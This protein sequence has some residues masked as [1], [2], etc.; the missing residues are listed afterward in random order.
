MVTPLQKTFSILL[1]S[2]LVFAILIT[3]GAAAKPTDASQAQTSQ[4]MTGGLMGAF[5]ATI[6]S[7]I[8]LE[9]KVIASGAAN[10]NFGWSVAVSGDTA[11]VGAY[12]EDV[13]VYSNQGSA[14]V[15]TRSAGTWS[16]QQ[17]LTASDGGDTDQ[18]GCSVALSGDGNTALIGAY[19]H[20]VDLNLDQGSAYVFVRSGETWTQQGGPLTASD[21]AAGDQ[22]GS[23]VALSGHTALV[24]SWYDDVAANSDQGTVYVF[25]RSGTTWTQ[26][27][28]PL[29]ASD[30]AAGDHFGNSVAL[31][32]DTA[33][34][35]AHGHDVDLNNNQGSAYIFTRSG[36]IWTQQ[37]DPLTGSDSTAGDEF[38]SSVALSGDTA[39]VGV[40]YD[41][42]GG[43][44][45]QGSAY[46]FT[47]SGTTWTQQAQLIAADGELGD[48]FGLSVALDGDTALVGAI[49]DDVGANSNQ[50]SVYIFARSGT[51]WTQ[52]AQLIAADGEAQ[53]WFGR[54]VALDGDTALAGT[55][56]NDAGANH[57][58]GAAYVFTGSGTSWS[59]QQKITATDG[60][61]DDQFGYAVA[62]D[63]DTALVG[64]YG[65]NVAVGDQ[66]SVYVFIRSGTA[67]SLQQKLTAADGEIGDQFGYAVALDGDTALV[68]APWDDVDANADQGSAYVF[69]R[70]GTTWT[71]QAQ[72]F[73]LDGAGPGDDFGW[74]VSLDGD[75]ALVGAPYMDV[76]TY[77]MGAAY[78]FTRAG[79]TWAQQKYL[80]ALDGEDV[81]Y[82]GWSV[83]LSGD[84]AL[85]GSPGDTVNDHS[86]QGSAYA[87]VRSG[88]SWS[89]Q[90]QLIAAD[91]AADDEFGS[92]VAFSNDKALIGA[93]LDTVGANS[94]QGSAYVFMRSGTIWTEQAHLI[95]SDG[96]ADDQ[97]GWSVALDGDT[98][99]VGA[100][101]DD[102]GANTEQGSVYFYHEA[103]LT[104]FRVYLPLTVR[105]TP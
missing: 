22:F 39:L 90:T 25:V 45:N 88:T 79:T 34:V 91:G 24:G 100:H 28:G 85:I 71:Q 14:Y 84:T 62:L 15:F 66:G 65:D 101:R 76:D 16:L 5:P 49:S 56:S 96:A 35:G 58:Q 8:Y 41:D 43:N 9:Q 83:S 75:T 63:G 98:A 37:G 33:L 6:D 30:G 27:G 48:W 82:F 87:F 38:G 19:T 78:V 54:S 94:E 47:R 46:V 86:S 92:S 18:F 103:P 2:L 67:W 64:A 104:I 102:V 44:N 95:A 21:G 52:Q 23:S 32:G 53:D 72:L 97:F 51:N 11:L 61:A 57:D 70:S 40:W 55:W 89:Q 69:T 1:V 73:G 3:P 26:Q 42:V 68:G 31:A 4:E 20:D 59:Q 12:R 17:E 7:L 60:D 77:V 81:Y 50:G 36:T 93:S 29:A 99:L 13:G 105:D 74:S 80:A 10:D